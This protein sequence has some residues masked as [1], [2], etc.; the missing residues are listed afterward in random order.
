MQLTGVTDAAKVAKVGDTG[1][2]MQEGKSA[3]CGWVIGITSG[4]FRREELQSENPTHL[5]DSIPEL[6]KT[7]DLK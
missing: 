6:A 3:G 7:F 4:A 5:I 2:D 1:S